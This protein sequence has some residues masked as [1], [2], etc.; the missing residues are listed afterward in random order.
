MENVI[1]TCTLQLVYSARSSVNRNTKETFSTSFVI[2]IV[3]R[4][5]TGP[6]KYLKVGLRMMTRVYLDS[7]LCLFQSCIA[8]VHCLAYYEPMCVWGGGG[9]MP[10]ES[11]CMQVYRSHVRLCIV[12]TYLRDVY[13]YLCIV[14]TY[15]YVMCNNNTNNNLIY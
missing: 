13:R 10:N 3:V 2:L 9:F 6:K 5:G 11:F 12:Y 1:N 8:T 4:L 14:Y 15:T 7:K